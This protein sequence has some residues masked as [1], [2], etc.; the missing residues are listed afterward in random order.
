MR[1]LPKFITQEEL[2]KLLE[3]I[4]KNQP[5]HYKQ[6]ML[7]LLLG[8]ESGLRISEI[9]GLKAQLSNCCNA[10][11]HRES[12]GRKKIITCSKCQ[13][14]LT[15]KELNRKSKEWAIHPLIPAQIDLTA[16]SLRVEQ[17]KGKKDRMTS[18]PKRFKKEYLNL[19]PINITP[20][21]VHVFLNKI[22]V[23]V[24]GRKINPHTL[25][26][27]Y[28]T[29]CYENGMD[30]RT[31]QVLMGH[32]NIGTTTIYMEVNPKKSIQQSRDLF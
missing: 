15:V 26:H 22:G 17:G 29:H 28:A 10:E 18:L 20:R 24:L 9:V 4:K 8:F 30:I 13:K 3:D 12:R 5:P 2:E 31:L 25:R 14:V 11:I 19:L 7:I 1:K 6:Y 32:S 21:G 16:N 27:G 23:R